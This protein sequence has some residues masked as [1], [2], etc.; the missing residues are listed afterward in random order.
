[1]DL[2]IVKSNLMYFFLMDLTFFFFYKNKTN[3]FTKK[4]QFLSNKSNALTYRS[5]VCI[6]KK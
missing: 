5:N 6:K 3:V 1:M 4:V 2:T